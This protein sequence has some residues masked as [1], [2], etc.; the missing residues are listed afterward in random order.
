MPSNEQAFRD[1]FRQVGTPMTADQYNTMQEQQGAPRQDF[2]KLPEVITEWLCSPFRGATN[3]LG[4]PFEYYCGIVRSSERS[5][6]V[7][8]HEG[9]FC[10]G[11][12][13]GLLIGIL[14]LAYWLVRT[15]RFMEDVGA[16]HK[17]PISVADGSIPGTLWERNLSRGLPSFTSESIGSKGETC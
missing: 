1:L 11:H 12:F 17:M 8:F 9:V 6:A 4:I 16:S 10:I 7:G 14:E 5:A 15:T 2:V 3:S 13:E